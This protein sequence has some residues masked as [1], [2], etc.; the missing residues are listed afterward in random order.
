MNIKLSDFLVGKN[1]KFESRVEYERT[2]LTAQLL[3]LGMA[4]MTMYS[5]LDMIA[6]LHS[7]F[8]FSIPF[9]FILVLCFWLIRKSKRSAAKITFLLSANL[10]LYAYASSATFATGTSFYFIVASIGALV[11][12]GYEERGLAI[13]FPLLSLILF[14]LSYF[15]NFKPFGLVALSDSILF[16]SFAINFLAA[17]IAS[18]F[19]VL[20]LMRLNFYSEKEI[21]DRELKIVEQ[22][23]ELIKANGDL[24][25][26][27]YSASHDLRAPLSSVMGL[28]HLSKVTPDES[29]LR[30]YIEMIGIRVKDLDRVIKDILN[31]SRNA[32]TEVQSTMVDLDE[33]I[34]SVWDELRFDLN[35]NN[36]KMIK[37]LP[38][39]IL[40]KTDRNRLKI[41]L[42]NFFS[43]AIKY[44]NPKQEHSQVTASAKIS[45]D[46]LILEVADNGIGIHAEHLPKIFDMFYR[47]TDRGTGSGLGLFIVKETLE[48]LKGEIEFTSELGKGTSF[49]IKIPVNQN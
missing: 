45:N 30:Q 25:R 38:E 10:I 36:I 5:V 37:S 34:Q 31:Y 24:D 43:N 40:V 44:A 47:A 32:R 23:K 29:E 2:L 17:L 33:L 26:F 1:Q 27:V 39:N 4:V 11:L 49:K 12:F 14:L 20:F 18:T 28:V 42:S 21:K 3:L 16:R 22:N 48:K 15:S 41:I 13:L 35:A 9:L 7:T 46:L 8:R 19:E 6:G